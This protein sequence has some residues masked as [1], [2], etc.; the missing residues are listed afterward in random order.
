R[1]GGRARG[2]RRAGGSGPR[3]VER[4]RKKRP[5]LIVRGVP[6]AAGPKLGLQKVKKG[7][8]DGEAWNEITIDAVAVFAPTVEEARTV[9]R[10]LKGEQRAVGATPPVVT[11]EIVGF[12]L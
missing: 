12:P 10:P 2:G 7:A 11:T 5:P 9:A 8:A 6:P 1:A 4:F 3:V